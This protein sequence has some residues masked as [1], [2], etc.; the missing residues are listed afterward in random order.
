MLSCAPR[1]PNRPNP[2]RSLSTTAGLTIP[3]V[4]AVFTKFP[5]SLAGPYDPVEVAGAAIDWEAELVAVIGRRA[6]R[7]SEADGWSH[8][9]GLTVGQDISDRHLQ[10]AAGAQY[11][12]GKSRRG[13][14]PL[15][16]WIV[17]LHDI[18]NPDDLAVGCSL[19]G[20]KDAGRPHQR[21]HL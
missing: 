17:T 15:G 14:G 20:G 9:A 5:A 11:S 4:P 1:W 18:D 3:E 2:A 7:V 10:I 21:P 19:N 8:V 13:Y 6:D 16:P 12:L